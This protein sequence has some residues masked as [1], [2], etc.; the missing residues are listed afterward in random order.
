MGWS[1]KRTLLKKVVVNAFLTHGISRVAER[2][3]KRFVYAWTHPRKKMPQGEKPRL[4][5]QVF[6]YLCAKLQRGPKSANS[7]LL[8][9][10]IRLKDRASFRKKGSD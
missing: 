6:F 4:G 3:R 8:K 1:K 9:P 2:K 10:Q 7:F 5:I